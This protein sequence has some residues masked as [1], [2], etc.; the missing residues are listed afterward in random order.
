MTRPVPLL[1]WIALVLLVLET[2]YGLWNVAIDLI[3]RAFPASHHYMDPALV[4]FIQSVSWLQEL[5]F[6]LGIAAACAAVWLYLD[7]S[8]W[9]L[10]VYGAN[11][12]LTKADWLISGFSG[13]EIFA[14][15]GY[16]SLM[17][18]TVLMGLLIWLSYR[19]TLE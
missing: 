7:W 10:A 11:V 2:G 12:F 14:M 3:I 8:I 1:Y 9:V 4:D 17:Y 18:Q 13:V 16:V 6:F 5:V 15:S 19:E